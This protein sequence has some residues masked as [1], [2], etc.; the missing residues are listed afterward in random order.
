[1]Q[2]ALVKLYECLDY[3]LRAQREGLCPARRTPG[4]HRRGEARAAL[5]RTHENAR[6]LPV[7][8]QQHIGLAATS[9]THDITAAMIQALIGHDRPNVPQSAAHTVAGL[10]VGTVGTYHYFMAASKDGLVVYLERIPGGELVSRVSALMKMLNVR[11]LVVD[12]N[13]ETTQA[14]ALA[15]AFPGRVLPAYYP[16]GV[17]KGGNTTRWTA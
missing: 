12:A 16:N 6:H 7:F 15:G 8:V 10:D 3:I 11:L 9:G 13:P 1:M 5:L 2:E 14:A 17:I 4:S